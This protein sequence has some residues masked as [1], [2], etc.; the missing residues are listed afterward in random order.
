M[1]L[2]LMVTPGIGCRGSTSPIG[3]SRRSGPQAEDSVRS[4]PFANRRPCAADTSGMSRDHNVIARPLTS[5]LRETQ[6]YK[7]TSPIDA[8]CF[9]PLGLR[10]GTS[11]SGAQSA[12]PRRHSSIG[13]HPDQIGG[14]PRAVLL[15]SV[16]ANCPIIQLDYRCLSNRRS[17]LA[18]Q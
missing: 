15:F 18:R 8:Q 5:Y 12:R 13:D 1:T 6:T 4:V 9:P 7:Y 11:S 14:N 10:P 2:G 17:W 3:H 16:S